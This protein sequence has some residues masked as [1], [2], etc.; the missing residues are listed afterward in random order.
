MALVSETGRMLQRECPKYDV[1]VRAR[2]PASCQLT[3]LEKGRFAELS[4]HHSDQ[5]CHQLGSY[6]ALSSR[7]RSISPGLDLASRY[8]APRVGR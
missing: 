7:Q 1:V 2:S 3:L 8:L 4:E 6:R 5:R